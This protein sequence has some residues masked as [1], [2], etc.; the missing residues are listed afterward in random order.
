MTRSRYQPIEIIDGMV[1]CKKC[2]ETKPES[3]FYR[4][5]RDRVQGEC[6]ECAKTRTGK[7]KLAK[8]EAVLANA[9]EYSKVPE[10]RIRRAAWIEKNRIEEAEKFRARYILIQSV[11]RGHITRKPC[12]FCG[13]VNA[14]AHH[15]DYAQPL[16]VMWLCPTHH[17]GRHAYLRYGKNVPERSTEQRIEPRLRAYG[18]SE[19]CLRGHP[20]DEENTTWRQGRR[21]CK[22]CARICSRNRLSKKKQQ[23]A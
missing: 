17:A 3:D 6:K 10:V 9:R 20:Y 19:H 21:K 12:A 2:G 16:N 7:H 5:V 22:A 18:N 15:D 14:Q 8:H 11:K 4:T 23:A 1:T 13:D